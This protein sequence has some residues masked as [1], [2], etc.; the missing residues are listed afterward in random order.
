MITMRYVVI[1]ILG[2]SIL[3][4]CA[5]R[6]PTV[7]EP[8]ETAPPPIIEEPVSPQPDASLPPPEPA[9]SRAPA[10]MTAKGQA[11][12]SKP[13]ATLLAKADSDL[14]AGHFERSAASLE[15]AIRIS[16]RNPI[17]WHRLAA[18]HLKQNNLRQAEAMAIKSNSLI[19]PDTPL[20]RDNW[21]IIAEVRRLLGDS[22]GSQEAKNR[23]R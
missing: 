9:I 14:Q 11:Q 21:L 16:P 19:S 23:A 22:K 17:I 4:G 20:A 6:S 15:R 7:G 13:V 5:Y 1:L 18:V 8:A 2:L 12:T 3:Q 10:P